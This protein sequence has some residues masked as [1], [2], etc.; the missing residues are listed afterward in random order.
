MGRE[1]QIRLFVDIVR[2]LA[3][4]EVITYCWGERAYLRREGKFFPWQK[5]YLTCNTN[6]LMLTPKRTSQDY[7]LKIE[8]PKINLSRSYKKY[9]QRYIFALYAEGQKQALGFD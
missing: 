6:T 1:T 2:C 8:L 9:K 5:C 7:I 4:R 3:G